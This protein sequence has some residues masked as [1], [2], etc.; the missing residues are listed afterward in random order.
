MAPHP[1]RAAALAG[2][3]LSAA[4]GLSVGGLSQAPVDGG[5]GATTDAT[6]STD[7]LVSGDDTGTAPADTG[8]T[9]DSTHIAHGDAGSDASQDR[10]VAPSDAA[11][12]TG[13]AATDSGGPCTA[14]TGCVVVPNGWSLVAFATT[15]SAA[16]PA[17][18]TQS[19]DLVEGPVTASACACGA[20]TVT[21]Q[22]S[23]AAGPVQV[24]YDTANSSGGGNCGMPGSV[25]PL[26]NSPAGSCGTDV[27]QG[28]YSAFDLEYVPPPPS[29]GACA[30]PGAKKNVTY[31]SQDRGCAPDSQQAAGCVGSTCV[32]S[33]S[34]A[35][36]ACITAPGAMSC[37]P[38]PLSVQHLVG[39]DTSFGCSACTCTVGGTCTGTVTLYSDTACTNR[40]L[41]IAADGTCQSLPNNLASR[42]SSYIYRG[43]APQG[44]NCQTSGASTAQNVALASAATICCAP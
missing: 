12:D 28:D 18:F 19:T 41:P 16:C 23:C 2:V 14:A 43:D 8:S 13:T 22:P 44:V 21:T 36:K 32:P 30:A 1:A 7:G 39:T 24:F 26:H 38:G 5:A 3:L 4:C 17:G 34:G 6:T 27:Y 31:A 33:L 40:A 42:Y 15:Q 25:T 20:C 9:N 35:Y 37:P 11:G 29:G 10:N